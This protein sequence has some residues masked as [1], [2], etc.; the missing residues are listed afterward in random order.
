MN[1]LPPL[2]PRPPSLG[3]KLDV[4]QPIP[5]RPNGLSA[6]EAS[7]LL[8][9]GPK[10]RPS[11]LDPPAKGSGGSKK[12]PESVIMFSYEK[13]TLDLEKFNLIGVFGAPESRQA[14]ILYPNNKKQRVKIGDE[15]NGGRVIQINKNNVIFIKDNQN[16]IIRMQ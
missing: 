13:K 7:N 8:Q 2:K 11:I 16:Y 4:L 10:D 5:N 3:G 6:P 14:L 9:E 15:F 12:R 1:E